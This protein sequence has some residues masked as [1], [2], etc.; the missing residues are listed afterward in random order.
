MWGGRDNPADVRYNRDRRRDRRCEPPR[1]PWADP[2]QLV[3]DAAV[4]RDRRRRSGVGADRLVQRAV[5]PAV[6]HGSGRSLLLPGD[7]RQP[8]PPLGVERPDRLRLLAGV[9]PARHTADPTPV[10]GVHG[11]LDRAPHRRGA[12]PDRAAAPRGR[13]PVPVHLD[14]GRGRQ[15]LAA[16]RRRDRG[17]VPLAGGVG[18]RAA[19]EDH[20]RNRA[21]VVRGPAASGAT[22]RSRSGRPRRSSRCRR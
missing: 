16:A 2:P 15:R 11:R 18:A 20:A 21:V 19:D 22:W 17:R 4:G 9:P 1:T 13:A 14:G 12:I 7:A 10:A 3:R 8:I 6:G 5:G